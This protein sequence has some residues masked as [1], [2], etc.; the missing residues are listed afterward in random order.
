MNDKINKNPI[1][2]EDWLDL[3]HVIIPTDQKKARVSWKKDDF[4]VGRALGK[5]KYGMVYLAKQR[6]RP[7]NTSFIT[8][9]DNTNNNDNE[10]Q[11]I[12]SNA[13]V[14]FKKN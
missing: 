13:N 12:Q 11:Q 5:G 3:G 7:S 10:Q 1:T 6:Q 8:N 9:T 2:Y 14:A 4:I